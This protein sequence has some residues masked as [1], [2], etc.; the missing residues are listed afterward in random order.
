M[1]SIISKIILIMFIYLHKYVL[2]NADW[3][4]LKL[5]V[6]FT[7]QR[8]MGMSMKVER[9]S[10]D[11][12]KARFAQNKKKLEEKKKDYDLDERLAEQ[13][14]EVRTYKYEHFFN[15]RNLAEAIA[16]LGRRNVFNSKDILFR[17]LLMV[18]FCMKFKPHR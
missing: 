7:D 8:N 12:V 17:L 15:S 11:Q 9:S 18:K 1:V 6:Y 16:I 2:S 4:P 5:F 10:L 13:R 3:G 14:E